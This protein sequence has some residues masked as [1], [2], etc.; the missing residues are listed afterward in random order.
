[1]N[2]SCSPS[3]PETCPEGSICKVSKAS[4]TSACCSEPKE[5]FIKIATYPDHIAKNC[6]ME[7]DAGYG[8]ESSHRWSFDPV[9]SKCVSF[10]YN[11]YGGNQNNFLTKRD[12]EYACKSLDR[13]DE[14]VASGH[15]NK[16]IS[17]FFYS[18][19]G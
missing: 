7:Q 17:R 8:V 13:C 10:M 9:S 4:G 2:F 6:L 12:C 3:H 5:L 14:P 16:Y 1:L 18:K 11:G 15:G 19:V